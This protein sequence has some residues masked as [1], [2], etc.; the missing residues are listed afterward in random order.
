MAERYKPVTKWVCQ[1]CTFENTG[2][3]R[4][5]QVCGNAKS[6][7]PEPPPPQ[8]NPREAYPSNGYPSN[9]QPSNA[10]PSNAYPSNAYASNAYTSN[11][12]PSNAYSSNTY[13]SDNDNA[14]KRSSQNEADVYATNYDPYNG[15]SQN[16]AMAPP[17]DIVANKEYPLE[18]ENLSESREENHWSCSACTFSNHP[19]VCSRVVHDV[20]FYLPSHQSIFGSPRY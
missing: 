5:C 2:D 6:E 8:E 3:S 9:A 20:P 7:R 19:Q 10:H 13:P 17:D 4:S 14:E 11:G 12:H 18:S 16:A 1:A 15:S